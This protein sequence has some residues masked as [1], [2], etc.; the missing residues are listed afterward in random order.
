[1][2]RIIDVHLHKTFSDERMRDKGA[3]ESGSD[4]SIKGILKE[5]KQNNVVFGVAVQ[6]YLKKVD[7]TLITD[8][9]PVK[10]FAQDKGPFVYMVAIN[11]LITQDMQAYE[12]LIKSG[13][14][15]GFK[16]YLGYYHFYPYDAV[17]RPFY[18]L[19]EKYNL[20][21]MFHTGDNY[22]PKAK[23][24]YAHPLNIDEVAVDYPKA[25]FIIAHFGEP[26]SQD[27]AEVVYKNSNVY[28]DL[29]GL[30]TGNMKKITNF[31]PRR[32]KEALE[33]C[34]YDKIMYG[35]D[36]PLA[37]MNK[38]IKLVKTLIPKKEQ[39]K[40]FYENAKKLFEIKD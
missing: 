8:Y 2:N 24:K 16:I 7:G 17:Y 5:M 20:I 39:K 30:V 1:M 25:R 32:V 28:A 13:K 9:N 15:K 27:A 6:D 33:Y 40:V 23:V 3:K 4:Y 29:S 38:Y 26:W 11:P 10:E 31:S 35:S 34:G 21:V 12:A 36:W 22:N 18:E 37:P 19:A 14:I